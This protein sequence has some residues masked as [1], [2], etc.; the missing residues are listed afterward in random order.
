MAVGERDIEI[1]AE[2]KGHPSFVLLM[3]LFKDFE[4]DVLDQFSLEKS[5]DG[6]VRIGRFYQTM[7]AIREFLESTPE[8]AADSLAKIKS[9]YFDPL[10]DVMPRDVVQARFNP[11]QVKSV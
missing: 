10:E 5:P 1:L 4:N 9:N 3:S 8:Q 11:D 7:R 6:M 2:L